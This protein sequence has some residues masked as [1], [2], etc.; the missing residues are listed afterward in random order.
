MA[1][2]NLQTPATI[3]G[4]TA[5]LALSSASE[6]AFIANAASS[7]KLLTLYSLTIANNSSAGTA[8]VTIRVYNAASGG[9]A[10][11]IGPITVPVGGAVI[12]IGAENRLNL[13][14]DRR[15]TIQASAANYLT[16]IASYDEVS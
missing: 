6:T 11:V 3:N 7:G 1:A 15:I 13:E 5:F 10:F 4:K 2:P 8:D 14:E 16:A 9:T 12:P